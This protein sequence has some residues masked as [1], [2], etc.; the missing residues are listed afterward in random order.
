MFW[1]SQYNNLNIGLHIQWVTFKNVIRSGPKWHVMRSWV[2]KIGIPLHIWTLYVEHYWMR[3]GIF[4]SMDACWNKCGTELFCLVT[5]HQRWLRSKYRY[6]GTD[7]NCAQIIQLSC[8]MLQMFQCHIVFIFVRANVKTP[9]LREAVVGA[10]SPM[11]Q[12]PV[13]STRYIIYGGSASNLF[14]WWQH[15]I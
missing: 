14:I 9:G 11:V 10:S 12:S 3:S 1:I 7:I 2:F 8:F 6:K 15:K 5:N 4:W 13:S